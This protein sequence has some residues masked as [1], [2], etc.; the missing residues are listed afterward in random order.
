MIDTHTMHKQPDNHHSHADHIHSVD[1]VKNIK[2]VWMFEH[3]PPKSGAA[4]RVAILIQDEMGKPIEAFQ[5]SHEKLIHLIVVSNDLSF[6]DHVHPEYEGQGQFHADLRFPAG[7]DYKLIA[8]LDPEGSGPI[9][10]SHWVKV[11]G[12]HPPAKPLTPE[13]D[14]T[15]TTAGKEISLAFDDVRVGQATTMTFTIKDAQTKEPIF[16][17]EP[18]LGAIGHVVAISAD[19]RHY[20]HIHPLNERGKGPHAK[21]AVVFPENGLYKLWGQFQHRG[22]LFTVAFIV[23]IP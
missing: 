15:K 8:D 6:F 18:Y 5:T 11:A 23:Q 9:T 19:T 22:T 7:G 3:E 14:M 10:E 2:S 4:Q 1:N 13:S 12:D 17:L 20:L 21:F 16:D